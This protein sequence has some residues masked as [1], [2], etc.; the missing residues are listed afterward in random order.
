M[1]WPLCVIAERCIL[2]GTDLMIHASL[3]GYFQDS[4]RCHIFVMG[5]CPIANQYAPEIGRIVSNYQPLGVKFIVWLEDQDKAWTPEKYKAAFKLPCMVQRDVGHK[6]AKK[7]GATVSPQ[8]FVLVGGRVRYSGRIDDRYP[9]LGTLRQPTTFDLRENLSRVLNNRR[10]RT[11]N[12]TE[13]IG[14]ELNFE[15]PA[16]TTKK[17]SAKK[18]KASH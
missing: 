3:I 5:D 8:A 9:K 12:R 6:I 16:P 14:C 17:S 1:E 15:Q 10:N 11:V 7:L 4:I 18:K 13:A 2:F